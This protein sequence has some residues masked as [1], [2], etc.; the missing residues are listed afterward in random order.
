MIDAAY[1]GRLMMEHAPNI[2][3]DVEFN[4]WAKLANI[5]ISIGTPAYPSSISELSLDD[6]IIFKKAVFYMINNG[7]LRLTNP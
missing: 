6:K 1:L 2:D 7:Y 5:L 4:G 3:N